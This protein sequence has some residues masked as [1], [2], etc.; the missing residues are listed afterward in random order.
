MLRL[1]KS[2]SLIQYEYSTP[3]DTI[4]G[5]VC[6]LSNVVYIQYGIYLYFGAAGSRRLLVTPTQASA[7]TMMQARAAYNIDFSRTKLRHFLFF[8]EAI[9]KCNAVQPT[10]KYF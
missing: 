6:F 5:T 4:D 8:I 2:Q 1:T 3:Q 9:H 7:H 10:Q